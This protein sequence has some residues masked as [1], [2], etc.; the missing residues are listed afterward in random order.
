MVTVVATP[1]SGEVQFATYLPLLMLLLLRE[2]LPL[3]LGLVCLH[4]PLVIRLP[5]RHARRELLLAVLLIPV[6]MPLQHRRGRLTIPRYLRYLLCGD[7]VLLP[8]CLELLLL[9]L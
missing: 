8:Q 9:R 5:L 1:R 3:V 4:L 6:G 7:P 2:H